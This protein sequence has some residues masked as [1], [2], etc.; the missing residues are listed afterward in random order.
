MT[1]QNS[2]FV[3][4]PYKYNGQW[5]FDDQDR[6]LVREPFVA[7]ADTMIDRATADIP[8]ADK[9]FLAIFSP[10][11]FPGAE[12]V[13][14]WV[15]EDFGGNIYRWPETGLEGWLCPSLL[16]FISPAPKKLYVQ[17]KQAS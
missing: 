3:I 17:V 9:G 11:S 8:N 15:G 16:K 10:E 1:S 5:V 2:I 6:N 7:G 4:K 13:L 14:E 12:I